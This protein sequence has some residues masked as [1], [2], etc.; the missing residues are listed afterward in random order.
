MPKTNE[1][2]IL[3]FVAL[4]ND[5][6]ICRE[7]LFNKRFPNG[8]ICP[9]CECGSYCFHATRKLYQCSKCKYQCSVTAGTVMHKSQTPL[10]KWFM[11]MYLVAKDKRGCSAMHLTRELKITYKCAWLLLRK[12][13]NAM[14]QRDSKYV[15][16]G[17]VEVDDAYF[18]GKKKGGKRGRGTKKSKVVVAVSKTE[19]EKPQY[20]K[21]QVVPNLKSKT[22]KAFASISIEENAQIQTDSYHSYRKLSAEKFAHEYEVFDPESNWLHWLHILVGNAKAFV[23]GT[24]HGL[25]DK[26][27][28][29]YLDEFCYRFNRR[30]MSGSIFD[31]LVVATVGSRPLTYAELKG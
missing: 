18:G 16:S 29:L 4:Y 30:Y 20:L 14:G 23:G 24:F 22:I 1:I 12:I 31:R 2:G 3:E 27:L 7:F 17:V 5:E 6:E 9:K 28:Q 26:H 19:D 8:F 10:T 21:M 13:R 15:L 11:A 25:K